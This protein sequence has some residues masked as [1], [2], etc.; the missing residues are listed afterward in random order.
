[1]IFE[2]PSALILLL[3][4][5]ILLFGL[6]FW[7]WRSKKEIA[8]TFQLN[9][10]RLKRSQIE[11]YLIAGIL[12]ALITGS[13]ALPKLPFPSQ[14]VPKKA[15]EIA[16]LV[17]VSPSMAARKEPASPSRIER[18]KPIL[19][20]I[21]DRMQGS[22]E[23]K[24]SL[25]GCTNIAR[26][27]VPFIGEEDFPYLKESVQKILDIHSTPGLGSSI[28][29]PVLNA[30]EKFSRG[31]RAKIIVLFSDGE[32]FSS[33]RRGIGD[34]ERHYLEA[35]V[36]KAVQEGVKVV[37]VGMGEREGAKIPLGP[38]G[39]YAS[40]GGVDYISYLE[41][42]GLKE[43]SSRT[44]GKYY[45]EG[46]R[47]GLLEWVEENLTRTEGGAGE[48]KEYQPVSHWFIIAALGIWAVLAKGFLLA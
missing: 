33:R 10:R 21:I 2:N 45:F 26:S 20:E 19:L 32:V 1:M 17:D 18:A 30:A 4:L 16:L 36:K 14:A 15:G 35:A 40:L 7:G 43:I 5:P 13:L 3:V 25:H 9:L 11:K 37:T 39:G 31:E 34:V 42:E 38:T 47:R 46:N 29:R 6:G 27:H 44:G 28:G 41:E 22:G 24:I 23:V 8:G 48:R 12:L